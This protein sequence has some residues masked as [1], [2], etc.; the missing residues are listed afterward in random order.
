VPDP[1]AAHAIAKSYLG[2]GRIAQSVTWFK[3]AEAFLEIAKIDLDRGNRTGALR[4]LR[5]VLEAKHSN[6]ASIADRKEA[7]DL[8]EQIS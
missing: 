3:R 1:N 5:R 6:R 2:D 7:Q 8:L 4:N